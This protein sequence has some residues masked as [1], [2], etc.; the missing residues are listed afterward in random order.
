MLRIRRSLPRLLS[1]LPRWTS[2]RAMG[3]TGGGGAQ[4]SNVYSAVLGMGVLIAISGAVWQD[5]VALDAPVTPP[6]V[7][8][9]ALPCM[10][11]HAHVRCCPRPIIVTPCCPRAIVVISCCRRPTIVIHCCPRRIIFTPCCPRPI[12][13]IPC[14]SR[15]T[16]VISCCVRATIIV[17]HVRGCDAVYQNDPRCCVSGGRCQ[18]S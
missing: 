5:E 1:S 3:M 18:G 8:T 9:Q 15:P 12:I 6:S 10:C 16:I 2:R 7:E 11:E 13:V 4:C 14:C 17:C